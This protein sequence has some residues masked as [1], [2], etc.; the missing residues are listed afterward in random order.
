MLNIL[1]IPSTSDTTQLNVTFDMACL[2]G[3][4]VIT[5]TFIMYT[6]H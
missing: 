6:A 1:Y 4:W 2:D 3:E 5:G